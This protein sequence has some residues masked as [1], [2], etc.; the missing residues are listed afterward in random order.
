MRNLLLV[1]FFLGLLGMLSCSSKP[2]PKAA[3][4]IAKAVLAEPVWFNVPERF[5]VR[6][7]MGG[8]P[9]HP[10]FDLTAFRTKESTELSYFMVTP[11]GSAHLYEM[12]MVSGRR[13][14]KL[15]YCKQD[16]IW[17]SYS[18]K[19]DRP[20]FAQG[21]VARLL[22]STSRPQ[23]IWVFGDESRFFTAKEG[24][25]DQSQ[26]AR[27]VGGVV[28]QFCQ[29]YPCKTGT[30]WTSQLVLIGVNSADSAM[31]SVRTLGQLKKKVD[32]EYTV[33]FAQNG[34][35]HSIN[36]PKP[37]P[38]YRLVSEVPAKKALEFVFKSGHEF[39][40]EEINSLRKNCFYLY[41]YIWRSQKKVRQNML[42]K[43]VAD[44]KLAMELKSRAKKIRET[45]KFELQTVFSDNIRY[46]VDE[47]ERKEKKKK[48]TLLSFGRYYHFLLSQ[49]GER[50]RTCMRFVRPGSIQDNRERTW[51]FAFINN[52]LNLEDLE[53]YYVCGG[54]TW[55]KN[56]KLVNGKRRFD[57]SKRSVCST[58][59]I[60]IGFNAGINV[61]ASLAGSSA[62]HYRFIEYDYGI[63]GSH[64]LLFSWV[65]QDGKYLGCDARELEEKG[66]LFPSDVVW[67]DFNPRLRRNR[68][69]AIR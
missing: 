11:K 7:K 1:L 29:K 23:K 21:I 69:D 61:M 51:F 48:N 60:D 24:E 42:K 4:P 54:K 16:D 32:W 18:G 6:T 56:P 45:R 33:A 36:G 35:G 65:P 43:K 37:Q 53:R 26:R 44:D 3:A 30:G 38:A 68:F 40:F 17:E 5:S 20:N 41:D 64:E 46:Q 59:A 15:S 67:K 49:Y 25:R 34:F 39:S 55:M 14:R 19:I 57:A 22:D 63:G 31:N 12:D 50:L 66:L 47:D 27:V 9:T 2:T 8:I 10:F 28:L 62:P 58:E 13:Y 52:W